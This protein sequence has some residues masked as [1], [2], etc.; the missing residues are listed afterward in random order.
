M[1]L[2]NLLN[3]INFKQISDISID[4]V[5]SQ[6]PDSIYYHERVYPQK[7]IIFCKTDYLE[8]L[9]N[10]LKDYPD[11]EYKLITHLSDYGINE[12]IFAHK[13][14]C[15]KKW[16]AQNVEYQHSDLIPIP[17]GIENHIGE[18]KGTCINLQFWENY[19]LNCKYRKQYHL[20]S[21]FTIKNHASR[22]DWYQ[23]LKHQEFGFSEPTSYEHYLHD[24]HHAYF[25]ASPRGNGL[26]CHRTWEALYMD[27]IPIVPK[28]FIYDT[29]D[30]PIIQIENVK[31]ITPEWLHEQVLNYN[32]SKFQF[33]KNILTF[34]YWKNKILN[35]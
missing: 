12:R 17:I 2:N 30:A 21:N 20:Y 18:S 3:G 19:E 6:G 4:S 11:G 25:C 5:Y 15:I 24:M 22:Q 35:D 8:Q 27:C 14:V 9:F 16:Y 23:H 32:I 29:F 33:N 34:E 28:H 26:D 31:I 7:G 10:E 13:P 1:Y